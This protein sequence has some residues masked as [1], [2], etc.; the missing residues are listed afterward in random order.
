MP[1]VMVPPPEPEVVRVLIPAPDGVFLGVW[2]DGEALVAPAR[3]SLEAARAAV[4]DGC[5]VF[6]PGA[7]LL[8]CEASTGPVP[9]EALARLAAEA[10][11]ARRPADPL[12][13]RP[14]YATLPEA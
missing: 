13:L 2:R 5:L 4:P 10:D 9:I 1:V 11:P 12:Y 14:P 8:G 6:G 3:L 7:P